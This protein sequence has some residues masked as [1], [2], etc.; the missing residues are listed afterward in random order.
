MSEQPTYYFAIVAS[1]DNPMYE[2]EWTPASASSLQ[3]GPS[4]TFSGG[5]TAMGSKFDENNAAHHLNQFIVHSAL[6]VVDELQWANLN[7]QN[8]VG[9]TYLK[10]VDRFNDWLISGYILPSNIRF[11]LLHDSRND[12]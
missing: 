3:V 7:Q 4:T 10:V 12:D 9:Q 1:N 8:P 6:D 2:L 11:M 5:K